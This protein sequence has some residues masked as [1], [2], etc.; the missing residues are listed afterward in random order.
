MTKESFLLVSLKEEKA[1]EL[2]QVITNDSCRKVL[3]YL[4]EKKDAT[5]TEIAEVLKLPLSTVHYNLQHLVKARLVNI[6]EFHYSKK[7]REV[8]HYKLANKLIIIA[9]KTTYGFKEKLKSILPVALI[10]AA[11]GG[12]IQIFSKYFSRAGFTKTL[13]S[14]AR[15]ARPMADES[16]RNTINI[17]EKGAASQ[18][19][20]SAGAGATE[21]SAV[22]AV[23]K[24][25]EYVAV[26]QPISTWH[27]I[28]LWF[29][30]G[31]FFTLAVYVLWDLIKRRR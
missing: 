7:G 2:A 3:D 24:T 27:N 16:L 1:K 11:A 12:I 21:E 26:Q 9:P 28:A 5:E 23:N 4:A 30:I 15:I 19:V 18:S 29:L 8:N 22:H 31:S 6:D 13:S 14:A 17:V 25:I 20:A 10:I